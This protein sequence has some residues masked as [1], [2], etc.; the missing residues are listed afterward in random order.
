MVGPDDIVP[1]PEACDILSL[2][3]AA[4]L[5]GLVNVHTHLELSALSGPVECPTFFDW[6]RFI[7]SSKEETDLGEF[8]SGAM[9]GLRHC[10]R[11]G[12][13]TVADTGDTGAA[14]EALSTMGGS[15]VVY[16]E[17]FGPHP[18]Q[19]DGAMA[20]LRDQFA[21]LQEVAGPRVK[22]G[23][24]PHAP[25]SVSSSLFAQ[26][27]EFAGSTIPVAMHL[28]ES[29]AES[30]LV[31]SGDGPFAEMWRDRGIPSIV[32]AQSP[33]EF[34]RRTGIL[35]TGPLVIHAIRVDQKDVETLAST[36][37]RIAACP[38]SNRAHGHGDPPITLWLENGV[39]VGVGTDSVV[40][41]GDL[42]LF[43]EIDAFQSIH[44]GKPSDALDLMT[45]KGAQVLGLEDQLGAL[46]PG[47]WADLCMVEIGPGE[48][49]PEA[50]VMRRGS[51][52]ILRTYVGGRC[53][54]AREPEGTHEV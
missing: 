53:V 45:R 41:V 37:C 48:D 4:V 18:D 32:R 34:V 1:R 23:V 12:V 52:G 47:F 6:I 11:F 26:V 9:R 35:E 14:V 8:S 17:V 38:V 22:L 43:R 2:P 21:G 25:Y 16:Q 10:W 50:A 27:A 3:E 19:S 36:G 40:S 24:S 51:A 31:R 29:E 7:R 15:G 5:P 39:E 33:V 49:E 20:R 13:T 44:A 30:Q 54:Y 46:Q 28:A 42:D